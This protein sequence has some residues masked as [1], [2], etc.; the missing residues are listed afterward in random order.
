MGYFIP[1]YKNKR[2]KNVVKNGT[3][4]NIKTKD[5]LNGSHYEV[6]VECDCCKKQYNYCMLIMLLISFMR[7]NK[8]KFTIYA[9]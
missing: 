8:Y 9:W 1:R 6:K 4:I 5:L 3:Y 7:K 2:N